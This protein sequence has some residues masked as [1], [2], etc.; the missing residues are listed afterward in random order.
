MIGVRWY[1]R[2]KYLKG[3]Q[4]YYYDLT[5]DEL[6][7][8]RHKLYREVEAMAWGPSRFTDRYIAFLLIRKT[9]KHC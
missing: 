6:F 7:L 8:N 1:L 3:F 5:K 9:S 2:M 4:Y